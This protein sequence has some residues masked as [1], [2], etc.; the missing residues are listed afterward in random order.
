MDHRLTGCKK[1]GQR[2]TWCKEPHKWVWSWM[3]EEMSMLGCGSSKYCCSCTHESTIQTS[4]WSVSLASVHPQVP[5]FQLLSPFDCI[6]QFV[7]HPLLHYFCIVASKFSSFARASSFWKSCRGLGCRV[8][9][10]PISI[11]IKPEHGSMHSYE[12]NRSCKI[13]RASSRVG[14]KGQIWDNI[15]EHDMQDH[16]ATFTIAHNVALTWHFN[17]SLTN[18]VFTFRAA[19][20]YPQFNSL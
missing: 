9:H 1:S 12:N 6:G 20:R 17:K 13:K 8:S 14:V 11:W 3:Y 2:S 18:F 15:A 5:P 10:A 19:H 7:P 16:Q 4:S